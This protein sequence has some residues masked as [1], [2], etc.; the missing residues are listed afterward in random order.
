MGCP[1]ETAPP[2]TLT[3]VGSS[4]M[5]LILARA[6]TLKASLISNME[7]SSLVRP[8]MDSTLVIA[9]T[10][11]VGK[12]IGAN[13]AS[14]NPTPNRKKSL[15]GRVPHHGWKDRN[16]GKDDEV[17]FFFGSPIILARGVAPVVL[18]AAWVISRSAAA[19]SFRVLALAA[20][21][22]PPSDTNAG[23]RVGNFE[24]SALQ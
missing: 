14:A 13:A 1:S 9:A 2:W 6:T 19:P 7:I 23:L 21:T 20:V 15:N 8:Q 18:R 22:V 17:V 5:S 3:R 24:K 11:A 4:S 16:I 12:S 10:G